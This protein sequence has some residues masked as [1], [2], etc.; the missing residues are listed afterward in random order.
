MRIGELSRRTGVPIPTIK[1]YLR[2]GLLPSGE[3]TSPN[4]AWY[5]EDH[6]RR[7]K[8]VRAMVEVG[9]LSVAA[10]REVL[11]AVDSDDADMHV[12]LGVAQAAVTPEATAS[13]SAEWNQAEQTVTELVKR[14][15]W[16][17]A[18]TNPARRAL[19]QLIVTFRD[20]GQED[21]LEILDDFAI[22]AERLS[23]AELAVVERRQDV[24]SRVEGAVVG[25]VLG[26]AVMAAMRRLA[27]EDASYRAFGAPKA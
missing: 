13:E 17:V 23:G 16:E 14:H 12:V 19:T 20:L 3:L 27:Q 24:D 22:A 21:L 10:T 9:N 11:G 7:L 25:I 5:G 26:D 2:E 8:L 6:V 18:E 4:Q 15:G 1:Y